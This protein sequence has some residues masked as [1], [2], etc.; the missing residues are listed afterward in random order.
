MNHS[1]K[2]IWRISYLLTLDELI[3]TDTSS[4]CI[5][6]CMEE[7]VFLCIST[8]HIVIKRVFESNGRPKWDV[9]CITSISQESRLSLAIS[10]YE[11][12]GQPTE[13]IFQFYFLS[14][15]DVPNLGI[16]EV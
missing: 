7:E 16:E 4:L 14:S 8:Q 13:C 15:E 5:R 12:L 10:G 3:G 2:E 1:V 6:Q 9:E 11:A